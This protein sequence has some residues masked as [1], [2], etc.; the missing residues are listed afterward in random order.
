[1]MEILL[2]EMDAPL[3]ARSKLTITA[4][5]VVFLMLLFA[6]TWDLSL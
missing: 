6:Y 3:V 1:M 2:V 4:S 5:M